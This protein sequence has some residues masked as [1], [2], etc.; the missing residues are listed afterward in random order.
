MLKAITDPST[1]PVRTVPRGERDL[2]IAANNSRVVALDN[3]SGLPPWLSDALCR[4]STGGG[5]GTRKLF[6]DDEETLFDATRPIILNGITDVATRADLLDRA[7]V[8]TLPTIPEEE[9]RPEAELWG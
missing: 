9:R 5:F 1:A 6:A 7:I 8:L 2:V 4:L 3:L